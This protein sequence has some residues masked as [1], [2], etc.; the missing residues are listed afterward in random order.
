[1]EDSLF[2]C[3]CILCSLQH[4]HNTHQPLRSSGQS[5][6]KLGR[7]AVLLLD[8]GA[9]YLY[10]SNHTVRK[11]VLDLN[12]IH[13]NTPQVDGTH[14][15]IPA[16]S[17]CLVSGVL[18]GTVILVLH[19][20]HVM[21]SPSLREFERT[22]PSKFRA[23]GP[24]WTMTTELFVVVVFSVYWQTMSTTLTRLTMVLTADDRC[25]R[26][27]SSDILHVVGNRKTR[28]S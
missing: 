19:D 14:S 16:L 7:H 3:T 23:F 4:C 2:V 5:D 13:I 10:V 11:Q 1:M 28:I 20:Q 24:S 6:I 25:C 12:S 26:N 15:F 21:I 22:L 18:P 27:D 17:W 8:A 9:S